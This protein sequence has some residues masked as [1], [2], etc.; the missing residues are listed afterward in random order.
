MLNKVLDVPSELN[1]EDIRFIENVFNKFKLNVDITKLR[2]NRY[3]DIIEIQR[4][5]YEE[6]HMQAR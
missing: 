2:I 3:Y 1:S 4:K 6:C 5:E